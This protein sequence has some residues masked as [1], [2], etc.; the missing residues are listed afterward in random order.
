MC[1]NLYISDVYKFVHRCVQ[2]CTFQMCTN[3]YISDVYE[4]ILY[5]SDVYKFVWF[6]DINYSIFLTNNEQVIQYRSAKKLNAFRVTY[7][8]KR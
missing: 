5:I 3:S 2:I 4:L 8:Y 7:A 6:K 1:T